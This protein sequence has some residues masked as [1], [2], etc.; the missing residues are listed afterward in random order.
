[1]SGSERYRDMQG[2][3]NEC[4]RGAESKGKGHMQKAAREYFLRSRMRRMILSKGR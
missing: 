1:M 2:Y 3:V 4:K